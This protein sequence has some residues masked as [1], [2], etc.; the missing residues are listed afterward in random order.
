MKNRITILPAIS[1]II[2]THSKLKILEILS[3]NDGMELITRI[4]TKAKLN[5]SN[6]VRY[7]NELVEDH[8]I[9]IIVFGRIKIVSFDDDNIASRRI[10][11]LFNVWNNEAPQYNTNPTVTPIKEEIN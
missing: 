9:K 4:S 11:F 3:Q 6:V 7:V 2:T 5:Y 8:I 1:S 10:K